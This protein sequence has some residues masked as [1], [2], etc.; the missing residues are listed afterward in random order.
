[1]TN[2]AT[3]PNTGQGG[4][5]KSPRPAGSAPLSLSCADF[6]FGRIVFRSDAKKATVGVRRKI[7]PLFYNGKMKEGTEMT[8]KNDVFLQVVNQGR[9]C[10]ICGGEIPPKSSPS[11]TVC[12]VE[13]RRQKKIRYSANY[14]KLGHQLKA[15]LVERF[16]GKLP[17]EEQIIE[18][19]RKSRG[20]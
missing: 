11:K 10:V 12:S 5:S 8:E 18:F 2:A 16:G 15:K 17:T 19:M 3:A 7:N 13:C 9:V 1:M 20:E 6:F 14:R 4:G